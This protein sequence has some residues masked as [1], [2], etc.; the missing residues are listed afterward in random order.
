MYPRHIINFMLC[1]LLTVGGCVGD[2]GTD[3]TI[4]DPSGTSG[5][6]GTGSNKKE[7]NTC[8][9]SPGSKLFGNALCVC[10]DLKDIGMI[11]VRGGPGF[12]GGSFGAN[13]TVELA[14]HTR[15]DGSFT[16]YRG[17]KAAGNVEVRD[18]AT[19][20][21]DIN[22]TGRLDVG[23]DL[24][25]GGKLFGI[26]AITVGGT[27]RVAGG[28]TV[29]GYKGVKARG[30]YSAP[31]GPPCPCGPG[32]TFDVK[33]AVT[34]AASANDNAYKGLSTNLAQVG[35]TEVRLKD[36]KYYFRNIAS[37]GKLGISVEGTVA[38]YLDGSINSIGMKTIRV[39]PGATLDLYISG[40]L[41]SVGHMVLGSADNPANFRLYIGG[42]KPLSLNIGNQVYNGVIYAPK[43]TVNYV[44]RTVVRG[45]LLAR[46]LKSTGLL[47]VAYSRPTDTPPEEKICP[48]KSPP[49]GGKKPPG[50]PWG[51]PDDIYR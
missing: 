49:P 9:K 17:L 50:K 38:L 1:V 37:M 36:G 22:I 12:S 6:D 21:R 42:D 41:N 32:K 19:S 28:E 51:D 48:P 33:E 35:G 11:A 39:S 16:P 4:N 27:L 18:H 47:E 10:E 8:W 46:T 23:K 29:L 7:D 2:L 30:P 25:V 14:A 20:T 24:A 43:A 45:G 34:A 31:A 26:G 3:R 15:I 44:G 5:T 40:S 13:G